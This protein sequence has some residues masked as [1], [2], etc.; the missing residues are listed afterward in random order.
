MYI[1]GLVG[2]TLVIGL[3]VVSRTMG[4]PLGP[5]FGLVEP[6]GV[7]DVAAK[8]AELLSVL[9]LVVLLTKSSTGPH[10]HHLTRGDD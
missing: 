2:I 9:G 7:I 4:I 1:A 8:V 5:S 3:Y 10:R 6:V